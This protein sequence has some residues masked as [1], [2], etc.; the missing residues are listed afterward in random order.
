VPG[1]SQTKDTNSGF[2][3]ALLFDLGIQLKRTE[4]IADDTDEI[5][6]AVQRMHQK[7]DIVFTGGGIGP[8]H[9]GT[10]IEPSAGGN[11]CSGSHADQTLSLAQTSRT[12]PSPKPSTWI[13]SMTR[14]PS[15]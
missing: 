15:R 12:S 9:D 10:S 4:V 5:V 14:R 11:I 3:A 7:Y 6:E 2:L 8:T 1:R 13:S